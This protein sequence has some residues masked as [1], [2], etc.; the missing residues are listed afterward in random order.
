VILWSVISAAFIGPGT[1]T[2]AVLAGSQF[3]LALLWT[4]TFSTLACIVLQEVSARITLVSGMTLGESL[5]KRYGVHRGKKLQ[6]LVGWSVVL[7]CAA[8]EA[9][10]ILGAV[11]GLSLLVKVPAPFL[12]IVLT[13]LAGI[14]LWNGNRNWL[15]NLMM[16]LVVLMG[17]AFAALAFSQPVSAPQLLKEAIVPSIP[18]GAELLV[19]GLVGT[20]IVPYNVFMGAGITRGQTIPLMRVGLTISVLIGGLITAAIL[21]AGNAIN[22]FT[23]F[24]D[25]GSKMSALAGYWSTVA[26][27][28][29]LFA[30]GF[31][32]AITSP[33]AASVVANTVFGMHQKWKLRAVWGAVLLT[34][35]VIGMSGIKPIPAILAVQAING[36]ILPL[37]TAYL[38]I[39]VNDKH[40]VTNYRPSV[41]YNVVLLT[42]LGVVLVLGLTNV[43][44]VFNLLG[45]IWAF[46]TIG[47]L[48]LLVVAATGTKVFKRQ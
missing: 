10:N 44:K 38:V 3:K 27:A 22:T 24:E 45:E 6:W 12:T 4:I 48:A 5:T 34:G 16:F 31:S 39:I 28:L 11:A 23:S 20:T 41:L 40:I 36:F 29:G 37:I 26:L 8:Y 43:L 25:L 14:V 19:L 15:A 47:C 7:G 18:M 33:Y 2:T 17:V 9:G 32:S 1:V 35:F 46:W 30:A 21:I 13:V 42:I